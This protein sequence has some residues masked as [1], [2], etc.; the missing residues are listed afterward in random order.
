[1]S[2]EYFIVVLLVVPLALIDGVRLLRG[3]PR[4][5]ERLL[6]TSKNTYVP[7][8]YHRQAGII[9][10]ALGVV[11]TAAVISGLFYGTFWPIAALGIPPLLALKFVV[12]PT[13]KRPLLPS[14]TDITG[15]PTASALSPA[16]LRQLSFPTAL[17]GYDRS[18]V[19]DFFE[20]VAQDLEAR[21][22]GWTGR[23]T[24]DDVRSQTFRARFQ[25]YDPTEVDM[26]LG[27]LAVALSRD[28]EPSVDQDRLFDLMAN[29]DKRRETFQIALPGY[30]RKEVDAF[31]TQLRGALATVER[32]EDIGALLSDLARRSFSRSLVGFDRKAVDRLMTDLESALVALRPG[33]PARPV[34]PKG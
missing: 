18:E 19:D 5:G 21:A 4:V 13:A 7:E 11:G 9:Y 3:D 15:T 31:L 1:M 12:R 34:E 25:G 14:D 27:R 17:F 22:A 6:S 28:E 23:L 26:L 20:Q 29:I 8:R 32:S 2:T 10:L 16:Q 24:T 30:K 33:A